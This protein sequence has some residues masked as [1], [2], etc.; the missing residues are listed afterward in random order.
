MA[1][2]DIKKAIISDAQKQSE[3]II[4]D[5]SK[6]AQKIISDTQ[7]QERKKTEKILAK[8]KEEAK[9]IAKSIVI[10][11][12]IK[13]K[14]D[15]LLEKKEIISKIVKRLEKNLINSSDNIY[16]KIILFQLKKLS[17]IKLSEITIIPCEGKKQIIE[18]V[19]KKIFE[20]I[21]IGQEDNSIPGG[22]IALSGETKFDLSIKS[23]I[24]ENIN[25]IE[26]NIIKYL[27]NE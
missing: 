23:L 24:E 17:E 4:E 15:L 13:S 3:L 1:L 25:I 5:A 11:A 16:E 10:N 7:T 12:K 19:A 20:K 9:L 26:K 22:L 14:K 6:K 27:N 21:T 2:E 8:A 18:K